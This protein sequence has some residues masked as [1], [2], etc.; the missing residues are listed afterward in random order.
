MDDDARGEL[1]TTGAN[2]R[3]DVE[4]FDR[5]AAVVR[6]WM[7]RHQHDLGGEQRQTR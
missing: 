3:V 4:H 2:V 7:H 6:R 5:S 1:P